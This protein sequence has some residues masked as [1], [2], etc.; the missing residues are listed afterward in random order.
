MKTTLRYHSLDKALVLVSLAAFITHHLSDGPDKKQT[1]SGPMSVPTLIPAWRKGCFVAEVYDFAFFE[2]LGGKCFQIHRRR[3]SCWTT[4]QQQLRTFV[5]ASK[6]QSF[7]GIGRWGCL[8]CIGNMR[9]VFSKSATSV[10]P[11]R[12]F[13]SIYVSGHLWCEII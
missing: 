1:G 7:L 5:S 6:A 4:N 13:S 2:D 12:A 9:Q 10:S 3:R 8:Q 11:F